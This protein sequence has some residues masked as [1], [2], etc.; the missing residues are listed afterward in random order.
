MSNYKN[1]FFSTLPLVPD[2][3]KHSVAVV[4]THLVSDASNFLSAV[5]DQFSDLIII[6]KSS[7]KTVE[8]LNQYSNYGVMLDF[9]RHQIMKNPSDVMRI[10]DSYILGR[11]FLIF[12]MGGYF[13]PLID[14]LND[15][16][17]Q[18]IGIIE[19]TENGHLR[20][21][22]VI[23]KSGGCK[24]PIISVARSE[25]KEPEDILVGQAIAFSVEKVLRSNLLILVNKSVLVIGYGKIGAGIC[26]AMKGRGA[27]VHFYD[28]DPLRTIK[29]LASGYKTGEKCDLLSNADLIISAT[30]NKGL[31]KNDLQY[32][33]SGVYIF[34][35]TSSDDE[36][37]ECLLKFCQIVTKD[38]NF[39]E[40]NLE[41]DVK[42]VHLYNGG[43]SIN[44]VDGAVVDRYIELVQAE[45]LFAANILHTKDPGKLC[46]VGNS[47]KRFIARSWLNY[48]SNYS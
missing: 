7:S 48:Y 4:V 25:L 13:L 11:K 5:K 34:T 14:F 10:L 19:D 45:M 36:F 37:E 44:F 33:K 43:N 30:G 35:A 18:F 31:S 12:D 41:K 32:V 2:L 6:P 38:S 21:L 15:R 8:A 3:T 27:T 28:V 26:N 17:G 42:K 47:E 23:N 22:K 40:V 9:T 16:T 39:I 29:A 1:V 20:Y 24:F 46:E